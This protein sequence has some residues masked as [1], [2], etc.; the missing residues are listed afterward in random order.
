VIPSSKLPEYVF[1][2]TY[3]DHRMAMAFAPLSMLM[4]VELENPAVVRKSYPR[5]WE[6]VKALCLD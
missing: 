1:V 2:N 3:K 4:R 6:D 5:Y